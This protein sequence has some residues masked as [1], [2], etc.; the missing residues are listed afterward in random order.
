MNIKSSIFHLKQCDFQTGKFATDWV[1][2]RLKAEMH[3]TWR[4]YFLIN[5]SSIDCPSKTT[6]FLIYMITSGVYIGGRTDVSE[7]F[8]FELIISPLSQSIE[9]L[10]VGTTFGRTCSDTGLRVPTKIVVS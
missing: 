8:V 7:T 2:R 10:T 9:V 5:L 1:Q 6:V 4:T 3:L